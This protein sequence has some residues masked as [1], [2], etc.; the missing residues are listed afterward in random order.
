MAVRRL[1]WRKPDFDALLP[2]VTIPVLIIHRERVP[3]QRAIRLAAQLSRGELRFVPGHPPTPYPDHEAIIDAVFEFMGL[4]GSGQP[5]A[6]TGT[7]TTVILYADIVDS[8]ALTERIGNEP[9][10]ERSR[11]LD[12]ALRATVAESRGV[13][14]SGRTL[15]D[16]VL[17]VFQSARDGIEAA[18]RCIDAAAA[19]DLSLHV[20]LHAG[21]V[22][23][24]AGNVYGTAVNLAARIAAISAPNEILVSSTVRDL[25]RGSVM[26]G[27]EDRGEHALKGIE[28]PVRVFAVRRGE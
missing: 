27:F 22:L 10:R 6:T 1:D 11:A 2:R 5:P 9:F 17:A 24:E 3:H 16:G 12:Q 28:D 26:V 19:N 14:V 23:H 21:D 18:V 7:G 8:T 15:G 20:G 4:T 13:A 25:S